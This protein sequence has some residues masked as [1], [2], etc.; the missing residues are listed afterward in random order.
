LSAP[1]KKQLTFTSLTKDDYER[2]AATRTLR[3]GGAVQ[4]SAELRADLFEGDMV[5]S[6]N[7]RS[8]LS[9]AFRRWDRNQV[10]VQISSNYS[11]YS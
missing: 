2:A 9:S 11:T 3:I 4:S 7:G 5:M 1:T 6:G 10:P 8:V